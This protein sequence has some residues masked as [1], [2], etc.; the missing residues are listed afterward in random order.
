MASIDKESIV[1]SPEM[2]VELRRLVQQAVDD[3]SPTGNAD[4]VMD[5]LER[6]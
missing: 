4:D 2:V 5:R 1:L 6:K 3:D